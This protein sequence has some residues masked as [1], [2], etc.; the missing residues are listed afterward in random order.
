MMCET[1]RIYKKRHEVT[2]PDNQINCFFLSKIRLIFAM[3]NN[4]NPALKELGC[5]MFEKASTSDLQ[6]LRCSFH[7]FHINLDVEFH[8]IVEN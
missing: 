2:F 4:N 1:L 3:V 7:S 5:R 8:H 6:K